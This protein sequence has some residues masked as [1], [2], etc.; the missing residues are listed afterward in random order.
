M[1]SWS[2]RF[3]RLY[4]LYAR[5][6]LCHPKN[7]FSEP[8]IKQV[9]EGADSMLMEIEDHLQQLDENA[10]NEFR[11][12]AVR[13]VTVTN[14]WDWNEQLFDRL[15]ETKGYVYLKDQGYSDIHFIPEVSDKRTPDLCGTRYDGHA[16]VEVKTVHESDDVNYYR[17]RSGKYQGQQK[18]ARE[19][20][21]N[22]NQALEK[23]LRACIQTALEQLQYNHEAMNRRIVFFVIYL[24]SSSPRQS[25]KDQLDKFLRA[26]CP[27]R[28]EIEHR[29]KNNSSPF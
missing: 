27:S 17:T 13:Y 12:K 8:N 3:P 7:Y 19:V 11:A 23:K 9:L 22:L 24:D 4:D 26:N 6:D 20:M 28:I 5:S 2:I 29:I 1:P 18:E 14:Q 21:S 25:E 15:N 16:L 10:W